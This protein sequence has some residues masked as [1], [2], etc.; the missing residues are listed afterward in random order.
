MKLDIE[1]TIANNSHRKGKWEKSKEA[2][3]DTGRVL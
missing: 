2:S 1:G 3:D